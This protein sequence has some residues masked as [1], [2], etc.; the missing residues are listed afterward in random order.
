MYLPDVDQKLIELADE[1][2]FV[3]ICM[4]RGERMLRYSE[5]LT[6]VMECIYRDRMHSDTMVSE[7]LG[8]VSRLPSHQQSINTVLKMLSDRLTASLVLADAT[9]Q[10]LNL[11]AWPRSID[12]MVKSGMNHMRQFPGDRMSMNCTFLP[13]SRLYRLVLD[14]EADQ[15]MELFLIKGGEPVSAELLEQVAD[16]MRL[17]INIWG[18]KH[19]EIAIHELA[20]AILQ[21]DPMKMRRLAEI[22]HIDVAS[23]HDMW[24]LHGEASKFADI[25]SRQMGE[26][27][28]ILG[29]YSGTVFTDI[30]EGRFLVFLKTPKSQTEARHFLGELLEAVK[31][32]DPAATIARCSNLQDTADVR[33]AYLCHQEYL[34]NARKIFPLKDIFCHG[35]LEFAMEC[36]NLI[37]RGEQAVEECMEILRPLKPEKGDVDLRKTLAAYLL[38]GDSSVT[39]T[40]ELLYL[41]KNTIKY[42]LQRSS[43]LLGFRP[44][45]MPE[46]M[47]LYRAAAVHRLIE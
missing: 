29:A 13:D 17:S 33:K 38:D 20:R 28:E 4:P 19:G 16:I 30:Y 46:C 14:S 34:Q 40:A 35:E 23:I 31:K 22:F 9:H 1:L 25:L 18:R 47:K 12:G 43:E 21:D 5:V 7:M 32:E 42:R 44:D 2:D 37:D 3:L 24:I 45:K 36:Q 41:H 26:I 27:R 39:R 6:E 15:A 8:R 10:I 11:I